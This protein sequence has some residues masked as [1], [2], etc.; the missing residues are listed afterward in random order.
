M[1]MTKQLENG[2]IKLNRKTL[3]ACLK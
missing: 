1:N 2:G 3:N